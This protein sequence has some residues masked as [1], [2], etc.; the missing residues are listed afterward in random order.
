MAHDAALATALKRN[1]DI[2]ATSEPNKRISEG[3]GWF[4]DTTQRAA[5]HI[6]NKKIKIKKIVTKRG[7]VAIRLNDLTL[8][9]VICHQI[10]PWMNSRTTPD[11]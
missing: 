2:I 8:Y 10:Q 4:D 11:E 5:V 6:L 3:P 1:S 9:D 7:F